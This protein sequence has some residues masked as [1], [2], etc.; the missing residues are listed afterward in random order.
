MSWQQKSVPNESKGPENPT[1][2]LLSII[3]NKYGS[4]DGVGRKDKGGG[5]GSRSKT[6]CM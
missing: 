6:S 4:G 2:Q 5:G 3:S 1:S